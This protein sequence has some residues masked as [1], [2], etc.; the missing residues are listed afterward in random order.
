MAC[1]GDELCGLPLFGVKKDVKNDTMMQVMCKL[2]QTHSLPMYCTNV[3]CTMGREPLNSMMGQTSCL[4]GWIGSALIH[5]LYTSA[6]CQCMNMNLIMIN[7]IYRAQITKVLK[8]RTTMYT[9]T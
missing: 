4:E 5:V 9:T 1:N 2:G 8:R 3:L 7:S 6:T